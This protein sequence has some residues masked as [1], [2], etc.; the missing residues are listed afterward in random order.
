MRRVI[1]GVG[2]RRIGNGVTVGGVGYWQPIVWNV[3]PRN[4]FAAAPSQKR[5]CIDTSR[6]PRRGLVKGG[7]KPATG[8][9]QRSAAE[10]GRQGRVG[11][12]GKGGSVTVQIRLWTAARDPVRHSAPPEV[13]IGANAP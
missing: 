3:R 1:D 9:R 6:Q 12:R 5:V 2:V 13:N 8:I 7:S 4:G 10:I 11:R